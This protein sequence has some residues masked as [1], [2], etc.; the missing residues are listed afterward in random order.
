MASSHIDAS[1]RVSH[2]E[3]RANLVDTGDGIFFNL[4]QTLLQK[5]PLDINV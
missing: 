2:F 3:G 4:K 5:T 1:G